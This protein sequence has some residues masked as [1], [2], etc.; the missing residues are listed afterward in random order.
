[1]A[2][3]EVR[4]P[5]SAAYKPYNPLCMCILQNLLNLWSPTSHARFRRIE[6]QF[7]MYLT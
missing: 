4:Q 7:C 1:M 2:E 3:R 6:R 5:P